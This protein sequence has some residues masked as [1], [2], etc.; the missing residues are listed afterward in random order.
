MAVVAGNN[1]RR[2]FTNGGKVLLYTGADAGFD[3]ANIEAGSVTFE[4]DSVQPFVIR[5]RNVIVA[6][7]DGQ[8]EP[9]KI[10]LKLMGTD[11]KTLYASLKTY[12]G[13]GDN[14]ERKL[15]TKIE[16]QF[17]TTKNGTAG[18]MVT[19][20]DVWLTA[21]PKWSEGNGNSPDSLEISFEAKRGGTVST[22]G[23]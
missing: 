17:P 1:T 8:E 19:F 23:S 6:I 3:I 7:G 18:D 4:P 5:D 21:A 22:Y 11:L 9:A 13:A 10:G 16:I 20:T 2:F 12:A 14:H 15:Y